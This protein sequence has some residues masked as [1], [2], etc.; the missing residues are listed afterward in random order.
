MGWAY[1]KGSPLRE[2]MDTYILQVFAAG[3]YHKWRA[4]D[5]V[6]TKVEGAKC[7]HGNK[8]FGANRNIIH[9]FQ[10]YSARFPKPLN[11]N[12]TFGTFA[13]LAIGSLGA[14]LVWIKEVVLSKVLLKKLQSLIREGRLE[15]CSLV[16]S[17]ARAVLH[18]ARG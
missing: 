5:W 11:L 18:E 7:L 6:Q 2:T 8:D 17:N 10:Q 16:T 1:R 4:D 14:F 12:A 3:I 9:A 15:P 13:A